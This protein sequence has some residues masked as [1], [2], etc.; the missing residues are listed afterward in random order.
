MRVG[1]GPS[2]REGLLHLEGRFVSE[3]FLSR[4]SSSDRE[5]ERERECETES[6]HYGACVLTVC[7][8]CQA[9]F[10][11]ASELVNRCFEDH[12]LHC[13]GL[14]LLEALPLLLNFQPMRF[15]IALF[16]S[17][18]HGTADHIVCKMTLEP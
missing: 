4:K 14:P 3:I 5:R 12:F 16:L 7:D 10:S 11:A 18:G 17:K 13:V 8:F 9:A 6:E 1:R 15:H 2:R